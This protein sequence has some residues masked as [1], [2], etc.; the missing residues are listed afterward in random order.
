MSIWSTK[1]GV[2]LLVILRD[3]IIFIFFGCFIGYIS[4]CLFASI[5]LVRERE[6]DEE[7]DT[8]STFDDDEEEDDMG[9]S[10]DQNQ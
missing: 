5:F 1:V 10:T 9:K 7:N 4:G 2:A 3:A 6:S 8:Q